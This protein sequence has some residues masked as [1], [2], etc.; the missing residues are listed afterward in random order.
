MESGSEEDEGHSDGGRR[1]PRRAAAIAKPQY[2]DASSGHEEVDDQWS[3]EE[4]RSSGARR[5]RRAAAAAKPNY[6]EH[7]AEDDEEEGEAVED[8]SEAQ[9]SELEEEQSSEEEGELAPGHT[10]A[11]CACKTDN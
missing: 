11:D 5:P 6:R 8:A 3:D 4:Q 9:P 10:P 2:R 7:P 1:R